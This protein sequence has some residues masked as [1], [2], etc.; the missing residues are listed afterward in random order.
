VHLLSSRRGLAGFPARLTMRDRHTAELT[1]QLRN[2]AAALLARRQREFRSLNVRLE[3]RDLRRRFAAIRGRLETVTG[4]LGAAMRRRQDRAE[5]QVG[6][7]VARLESLSPL[8]V[9]GRGYSV[10]W[11]EDRTAI[12]RSARAVRPGARV[13]VTLLEGAL[14]CRVEAAEAPGEASSSEN[15]DKQ[16]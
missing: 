15:G 11:N 5:A 6:S 8:A 13:H 14:R 3:A 9:L 1:H 12:V 2:A 16:A 4:R 10:C 7:R